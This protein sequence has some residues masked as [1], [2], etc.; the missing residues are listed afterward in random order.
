M[1]RIRIQTSVG[2][3]PELDRAFKE[4]GESLSKDVLNS[5]LNKAVQPTVDAARAIAPRSD[6]GDH[7]AD[8]IT[9]SRRITKTQEKALGGRPKGAFI[10]VGPNARRASHG[11]LIEDG[12]M[13]RARGPKRPGSPPRSGVAFVGPRPFMRP[14]WEITKRDYPRRFV[15]EIKPAIE[16]VLR[17]LNRQL[18]T[19]KLS[20]KT[21]RAVRG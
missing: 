10:A 6:D 21:R 20:G 8:A 4:L 1:A 15:A 12:H 3:L 19:G 5:A 2:G 17:K 18:R 14:A 11:H 9:K 16:K 13:V 7:L